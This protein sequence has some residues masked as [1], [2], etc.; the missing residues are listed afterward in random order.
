[1]PEI[2]TGKPFGSVLRNAVPIDEA[3][4]GA[5]GVERLLQDIPKAS[6]I[7][8][9]AIFRAG[10]ASPSGAAQRGRHRGDP[11]ARRGQRLRRRRGSSALRNN[12]HAA[13]RWSECRRGGWTVQAA[14]PLGL[15]P[16]A[17]AVI[18]EALAVQPHILGAVP[19][20]HLP[21]EIVALPPH[22]LL[23]H[24][25]SVFIEPLPFKHRP[26]AEALAEEPVRKDVAAPK[27]S[28]YLPAAAACAFGE[29]LLDRQVA[30][31]PSSAFS[32][33]GGA[34]LRP[35]ARAPC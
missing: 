5:R 18:G 21:F 3:T 14:A 34:G 26:L 16:D 20:E 12:R 24:R 4:R 9:S 22:F 2:V 25:E 1:M 30:P 8:R 31:R 33:R 29:W 6:D 23:H 35:V 27:A 17:V 10:R 11:A 32:L 19:R 28:G 7:G 13:R 15:A